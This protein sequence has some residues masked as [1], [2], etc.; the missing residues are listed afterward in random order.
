M[1]FAQTSTSVYSG[2][3]FNLSLICLDGHGVSVLHYNFMVPPV[4]ADVHAP[5][6]VTPLAA[7]LLRTEFKHQFPGSIF[8][9]SL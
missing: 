1:L 9:T 2:F 7:P 5:S 6:D 8:S 3:S 4:H